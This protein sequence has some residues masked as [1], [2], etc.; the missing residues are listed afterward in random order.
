MSKKEKLDKKKIYEIFGLGG[1][2]DCI[3]E[4]LRSFQLHIILKE[5]KAEFEQQNKDLEEN[6]IEFIQSVRTKLDVA[7]KEILENFS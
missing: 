7:K 2:V 5:T 3:T 1:P 6:K 4:I